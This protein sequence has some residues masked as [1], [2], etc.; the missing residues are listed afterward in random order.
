[1]E[2]VSDDQEAPPLTG[3]AKGYANLKPW[4]KGVSG[5]KSGRPKDL[6]KFGEILMREFYKTVVANM[7]GKTVKKTQGELVAAQMVKSAIVKGGNAASLLLKFIEAHE[8]RAAR[9]EEL[10]LKKQADGSEEIDWDAER[11]EVYQRLLKATAEI[12]QLPA[13]N[14]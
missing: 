13:N 7:G 9:R 1:V 4:K 3:K 6:G 11:E 14:E 2:I 12:V 8:A 5:N 10:K